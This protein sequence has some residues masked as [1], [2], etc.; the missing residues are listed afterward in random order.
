MSEGGS[1]RGSAMRIA[2]ALVEDLLA[3]ELE[4]LPLPRDLCAR[5]GQRGVG[6]PFGT[7]LRFNRCHLLLHIF[8]FPAFAHA[9]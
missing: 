3:L 1:E 7:E 6:L 8:T 9:L 2:G 5:P 4:T